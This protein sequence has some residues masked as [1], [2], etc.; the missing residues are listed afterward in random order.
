MMAFCPRCFFHL[1]DCPCRPAPEDARRLAREANTRHRDA[2]QRAKESGW[3]NA[4]RP[5]PVVEH[6]GATWVGAA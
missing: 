2:V 3:A 5:Q 6:M 4:N 1:D